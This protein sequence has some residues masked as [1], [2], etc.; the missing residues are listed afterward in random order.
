MKPNPTYI[1]SCSFGKDSIATV[2]L[3][4]I[5]HEPLNRIVFC[6][7]MFDN[8]RSISGEPPEHIKWV[9]EVAVPRIREITGIETDVIRDDKRDYITTFYHKITERSK[10][11]ERIGKYQGFPIGGMCR[12]QRDLKLDPCKRYFAQFESYVQYLGIAADE[13]NRLARLDG[14]HK[15]SLLAKYGYTEKMAYNLC[16][17]YDLLSPI[18]SNAIRGGCWFCPNC[19]LFEFRRFRAAHPELWNELRELSK[20]QNTISR[21]FKYGETF[22]HLEKRMDFHDR[23]MTLF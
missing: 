2:L 6:E 9:K 20:E 5:N 8:K 21:G 15:I 7:V 19:R 1:A 17:E 12:I 3:A 23:Q 11:K 4:A 16:K 18:Y 13:P 10:N 14:V 22:E